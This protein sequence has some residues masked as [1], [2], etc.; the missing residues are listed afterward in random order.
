MLFRL[1]YIHDTHAAFTPNDDLTEDAASAPVLAVAAA[2]VSKAAAAA[3]E[4]KVPPE[5]GYMN[6]I[7]KCLDEQAK[8]PVYEH[9][10]ATFEATNNYLSQNPL[11]G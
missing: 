9:L 3:A 5:I 2:V 10:P 6:V 7:P 8:Y 1:W 11:E 4:P